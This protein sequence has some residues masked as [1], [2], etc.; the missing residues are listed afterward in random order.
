MKIK[1]FLQD[2][3]YHASGNIIKAIA[4]IA[5]A[6]HFTRMRI[7]VAYA[8]TGGCKQ[9][10]T[11]LQSMTGWENLRKEW[12]VGIDYGITDADALLS[13]ANLPNSSVRIPDATYLLSH[14]L[15]PL[16]SFHPK[17]YIFDQ[18]NDSI[19][20]V[21]FGI[22]ITSGNLTTNGLNAGVEHATALLYGSKHPSLSDLLRQLRWWDTIWADANPINRAII[23]R[24][25]KLRPKRAKYDGE[26]I[27]S[28]PFNTLGAQEVVT[29]TGIRW[30][31][32]RYFWIHAPKELY[33]N[34]GKS[35]PGNQLDMTR[36]TRVFFGLTPQ[37]VPPNTSLGQVVVKFDKKRRVECHLRF[38]N[39][40]MDKIDLPTPGIDGPISYDDT[41][42]RFEKITPTFF[43]IKLATT[44]DISQWRRQSRAQGLCYSMKVGKRE[45]GF[46][47]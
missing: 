8:T 34:R 14:Q 44:S 6:A 9:L 7:S 19:S 32:A 25:K 36:G 10:S 21:P 27:L 16:R 46:Y 2:S 29:E 39:N 30:A 33:K 15:R 1:Y 28:K 23:T 24:Y 17:T 43:K 47:S 22:V 26:T 3:R 31:H 13:L 41:F 45:Y 11:M 12:L 38:G 42:I 35:N 18:N 40:S 4:T 20:N 37:T 5:K